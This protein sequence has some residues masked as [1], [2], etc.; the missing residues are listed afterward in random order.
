MVFF[1]QKAGTRANG[2]HLL[3]DIKAGE[4]SW[5]P[6]FHPCSCDTLSGIVYS[7][8]E[9]LLPILATAPWELPLPLETAH[10]TLLLGLQQ[11][12]LWGVQSEI[13]TFSKPG[14]PSIDLVLKK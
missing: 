8:K 3:P 6:R 10:P 11:G 12:P 1:A 2:T 9:D 5:P 14:I 4:C 13:G 7:G